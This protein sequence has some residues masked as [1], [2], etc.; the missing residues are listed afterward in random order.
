MIEAKDAALWVNKEAKQV[1]IIRPGSG[2]SHPMCRTLTMALL[3]RCL[4]PNTST[5]PNGQ[6]RPVTSNYRLLMARRTNRAREKKLHFPTLSD[7]RKKASDGREKASDR[8]FR[9]SH[10]PIVR[11]C[12]NRR[13]KIGGGLP[14]SGAGG[15]GPNTTTTVVENTP[16][17][18][19]RRWPPAKI[20]RS[21]PKK[22]TAASIP[23]REP[24]HPTTGN[25]FAR[26]FL[27][28]ISMPC[29]RSV[30]TL[31]PHV[32]AD[33]TSFFDH[34]PDCCPR[35]LLEK[36]PFF[37]M[38]ANQLHHRISRLVWMVKTSRDRHDIVG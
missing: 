26:L 29:G 21:I 3:G 11:R 5:R 35:L 17:K 38:L 9:H 32:H 12:R 27:V 8:N 16:S 20:A 22:S 14:A 28:A 36:R 2:A 19:S 25:S 18:N 24:I 23:R 15:R 6:T 1:R 10:P 34:A 37:P 31:C 4:E 13:T 33:F 30:R 7:G